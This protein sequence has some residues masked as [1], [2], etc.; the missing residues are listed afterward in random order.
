MSY[1][2]DTSA[3]MDAW[4]RWY[5]IDLFPSL[6]RR[7]DKLIADKELYSPEEVLIEISKKED[8][9]NRWAK[10]RQQMFQPPDEP[11]QFAL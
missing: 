4:V 6:W 2:I 10:D 1:C 9:L 11:V 5:P 8:D 7:V 3:L